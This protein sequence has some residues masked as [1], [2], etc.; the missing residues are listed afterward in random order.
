MAKYKYRLPK[1]AMHAKQG[2]S[3]I[4]IGAYG[5]KL[6]EE[7][8]HAIASIHQLFSLQ[9][10]TDALQPWFPSKEQGH[11]VLDFSNRYFT[12]RAHVYGQPEVPFTVD[13]DPKGILEFAGKNYGLHLEDNQVLY[14]EG[15]VV[16]LGDHQ[17]VDYPFIV[18]NNQ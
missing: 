8:T 17:Y 12:H 16:Q 15:S 2:V 3:L 10:R 4:G 18:L 7:Y 6:F 5:H 9:Y 14:M 13:V 11:T 1:Q